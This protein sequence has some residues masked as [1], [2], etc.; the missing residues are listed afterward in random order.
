MMRLSSTRI[1]G[2]TSS[3]SNIVCVHACLSVMLEIGRRRRRKRVRASWTM[4]Q[5]R[6]EYTQTLTWPVIAV[7]A[8]PFS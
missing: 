1:G 7:E 2:R 8:D 3:N 6:S 5:V 4:G